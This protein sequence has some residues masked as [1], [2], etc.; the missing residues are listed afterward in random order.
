M[1]SHERKNIVFGKL[2]KKN[3]FANIL[4]TRLKLS[5]LPVILY[6]MKF[7][8]AQTSITRFLLLIF[9]RLVSISIYLFL[10]FSNKSKSNQLENLE[11]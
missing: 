11:N 7:F 4:T 2:L 6:F 10:F 9:S 3:V 1:K 5:T 8:V